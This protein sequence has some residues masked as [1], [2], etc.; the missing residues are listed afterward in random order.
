MTKVSK[1]VRG[2]VM[3]RL[4]EAVGMPKMLYAVDIWGTEMLRKGRG[5]DGAQEASQNRSTRCN[6]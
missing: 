5:R 3:K 1:G 2:T 4:H 6:D